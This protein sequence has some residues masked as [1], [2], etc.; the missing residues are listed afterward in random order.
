MRICAFA[1]AIAF[2]SL[3]HPPPANASPWVGTIDRQLHNDLQTL[4]EWGYIDLA[5]TA[6][7]VPWKGISSALRDV[8][9]ATMPSLPR[10]AHTRLMYYSNLQ[11][12]K[13]SRHFATLQGATDDVRFRSFDDGVQEKG[14]ISLSSEFYIGRVSAQLTL[15]YA[16]GGRTNLDNSFIA[17]QFGSWNVR[18]GSIDQFWG[19]AQ[20]SSLILSTNT[21]PIKAIALSR[22]S[23][24]RSES[25]W[26][27]WLGPWYFTTQMGQLESDR[28]VPDAKLFLNRA[29]VRPIKGL[30]IGFSWA[31]MWGGEGRPEDL[32]SFIEVITFES[33]CLRPDGICTDAQ[34]SKRGNHLAGF[35][36]T[37]SFNLFSRPITL[38]GQRIGEDSAGTFNIT[39]NANLFGI[40]TYFG[41]AKVFL[42]TS[43]TNVNCDGGATDTFDCYYENGVYE[44]GYRA[45]GRAIGSTFDSDAR[46][47]TLGAN[48]RFNE[49]AVAEL[50]VRHAELNQDGRNPSPVLT[51]SASE[52]LLELSGFYRMP[53]NKWLLTAGGTVS[54]RDLP[55]G[56]ET[57]GLLY[58]KAQY[59]F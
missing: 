3:I 58:F 10:L 20:S 21:R 16:D 24:T 35:D 32:D 6:Y 13:K 23:A 38:Y 44:S 2:L 12:Q 27:S 42:E 30:E 48:Y 55:Q 14:K 4:V 36:I 51:D 46:Q 54:R 39:D 56:D 22:S 26:L 15:N 52:D 34:L 9:P 45:Y 41:N 40:S 19:P 25:P 33:V 43:D 53:F 37:Y 57:D 8:D 28:A 11:A 1:F 5:V 31:A 29:N 18:V 50:Y 17:Y 49:G 47:I 59:A 7:P